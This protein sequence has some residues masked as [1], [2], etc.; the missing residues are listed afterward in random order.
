MINLSNIHLSLGGRHILKGVD[1][2]VKDKECVAVVGP[3][4]CGKSTLLRVIAGLEEPDSGEMNIPNKT[5]I[6]YLPQEAD[7]DVTHSLLKELLDAF[8]EVQTALAEMKELEHKMG[9][10]NPTSDEYAAILKKYAELSHLVEH[11]EGYSLEARAKQV[12]AGLGFKPCDFSRPCSEFS[13]GWQM[14]ILLAKILLRKLDVILLDEPTNH[15][16]LESML[17]LEEWIKNCGRTVIMVSHERAFMDRLVDRIICL[18][19]GKADVYKGDYSHYVAQS[20][21][22]REAH[23]RAFTQQQ[24]EIAKIE[25]FI[26]KF[27]YN[28]SRASLVQSRIKQLEKIERIPPPFQPTAIHFNF[29]PA[30]QSFSDVIKLKNLGH[31]YGTNKV[32][33]GINL[34]ITRGEKIGL[35]GVN[36]AGKS[37]LLR[38][39]ASCEEAAEGKCIIGGNVKIAYFAQYDASTLESDKTLLQAIEDTAPVGEQ[40]RARDLLG[41]FLFSGDDVDKPLRALSGGERTRFRLASMLFSPANFLVLDEPT[42][43]LDITSRATVEEALQSYKG[44]VIVV[45]HDRVFM[46]KVTTKIIE[47]ENRRANIYPG[48]YNDYLAYKERLLAEESQKT[49]LSSTQAAAAAIDSAKEQ[50]LRSR[51]ERKNQARKIN[52]VRKKIEATENE[53]AQQEA[54]LNE[55]HKKISDPAIAANYTKLIPLTTEHKQ[56]SEKYHQSIEQWEKLQKELEEY[57]GSSAK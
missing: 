23:W 43:H 1:L 46:D 44:T 3:N 27:R 21:V 38:I 39:L 57:N 37:T 17:W 35:V 45:S 29:P 54:K 18:E 33:S 6:G 12:A 50:R 4:G 48:K 28:A 24:E 19:M 52:T 31:S 2:K 16:D 26:A 53:I 36:G 30:P 14:R 15:L 22:K 8:S 7:V 20:T 47:I 55:L 13:G 5:T 41:A 10:I 11:R 34:T 9:Y 51:E 42:N 40:K 49:K 25:A 56:I 32:F